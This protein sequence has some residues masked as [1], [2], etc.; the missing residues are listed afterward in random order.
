[1]LGASTRKTTQWFCNDAV[2]D[3]AEK[4][5][6]VQCSEEDSPEHPYPHTAS[7]VGKHA[8]GEWKS[9]GSD[10]YKPPLCRHIAMAF[11]HGE[12]S[13]DDACPANSSETDVAAGGGYDHYNHDDDGKNH[14]DSNN[15]WR[16]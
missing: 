3:G 4:Y 16:K 13:N 6:S 8:N 5:L 2:L 11:L 1:M 14:S 15:L 10:Q 9:K 7:L 12:S